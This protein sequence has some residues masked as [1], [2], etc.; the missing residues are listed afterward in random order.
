MSFFSADGPF[1]T[2]MTLVFDL[3][4]LN[5]LWII[6]SIPLITLGASSIAIYTIMLKRVRNNEGY[7]IKG[8]FG[9]LKSNFKESL[10]MTLLYLALNIVAVLDLLI[11]RNWENTAASI[12]MGLF[13]FLAI[14]ILAIFSYVWPLMAKFE[15]TRMN[16]LK[17][18]CIL[19]V[20]KLPITIVLVLLNGLPL[21]LFFLLPQVFIYVIWI[22]PF[23]GFSLTAYLNSKLLAPLFDKLIANE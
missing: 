22:Y 8:F 10:P 19:A 21:F 6:C 5:F 3:V 16:T 2:F 4:V 9:A 15:N 17:N 11:I 1:N 14:V 13:L 12:L 18:A 20:G 7:I 23:F